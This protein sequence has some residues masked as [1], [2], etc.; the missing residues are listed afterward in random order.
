[1]ADPGQSGRQWPMADELPALSLPARIGHRPAA[2]QRRL[3]PQQPAQAASAMAAASCPPGRAVQAGRAL[4]AGGTGGGRQARA[5][6]ARRV[7][8]APGRPAETGLTLAVLGVGC[9]IFIGS[10]PGGVP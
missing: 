8:A 9:Y 4:P 6:T 10:S 3:A 7:L 1:M 2:A 5:E